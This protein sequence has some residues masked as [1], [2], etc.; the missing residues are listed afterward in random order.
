MPAPS[1]TTSAFSSD[2]DFPNTVTGTF[3]IRLPIDE[4]ISRK[5]GGFAVRRPI[6]R[7]AGNHR[8]SATGDVDPSRAVSGWLNECQSGGDQHRQSERDI[9]HAFAIW[10]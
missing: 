10:R 8:S 2:I 6:D 5:R 4:V 9:E 7:K 3:Q 1:T